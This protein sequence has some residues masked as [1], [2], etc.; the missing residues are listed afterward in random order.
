M[1]ITD[2]VLTSKMAGPAIRAWHIAEALAVE[3]EVVLATTSDLCDVSSP[4]F[5]VESADRAR[6]E[7]LERWCDVA[8]VQ[9]YLLHNVPELRGS[10]Q[11]HGVRPL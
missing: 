8:V 9:G 4:H 1:V 3:Q 7:E 6:F 10:Q 5:S 2:D 11:G